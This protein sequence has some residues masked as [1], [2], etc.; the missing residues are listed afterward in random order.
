M[1]EDRLNTLL[2][3]VEVKCL[4]WSKRGVH[5]WEGIMT[6]PETPI[7]RNPYP[8]GGRWGDPPSPEYGMLWWR[9]GWSTKTVCRRAPPRL[10]GGEVHRSVSVEMPGEQGPDHE[11]E[12]ARGGGIGEGSRVAKEHFCCSACVVLEKDDFLSSNILQ[13]SFQNDNWG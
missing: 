1:G 9:C 6:T 8:G 5:C 12:V 10:G 11:G 2:Y 13:Q 7:S 3:S 4:L